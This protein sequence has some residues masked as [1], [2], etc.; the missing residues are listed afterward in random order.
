MATNTKHANAT[1]GVVYLYSFGMIG[2]LTGL[3]LVYTGIGSL[4][5]GRWFNEPSGGVS[6]LLFGVMF[7]GLGVR[8]IWLGYKAGIRNGIFK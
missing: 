1:L 5:W 8:M 6:A 7:A 2:L 4:S 3:Y